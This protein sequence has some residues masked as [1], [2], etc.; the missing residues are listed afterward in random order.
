MKNLLFICSGNIDRSP[1]AESLFKNSEKYSA[2]SA[3]VGPLTENPVRKEMVEWADIIFV[4]EDE[5]K[6]LLLERFPEVEGIIVLEVGNNFL[7]YDP[8][9]ENILREKLYRYL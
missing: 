8:E 7:R 4:M 6:R 3:G 1:C 9:L 2:K 5:H